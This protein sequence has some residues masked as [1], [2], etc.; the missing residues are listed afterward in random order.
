LST[1]S[2]ASRGLPFG[3]S[4]TVMFFQT[5]RRGNAPL[6]TMQAELREPIT[7]RLSISQ[8]FAQTGKSISGGIGA[9]YTSGFTTVAFDY[10]NYYV[11]LREPNPFMRALNLTIRLQLGNSSVNI[12][13]TVDPFGRVTYAASGSTYLYMGELAPGVQ[14]LTI[15]FERYVIRGFVQDERGAPI[16]GAAL[17]VGGEIV[18]TNSRGEFFVRTKNRRQLPLR[19]AFDDFLAV[20]NFEI[21]SAPGSVTPGEEDRAEPIRVVL[22]AVNATAEPEPA[23][24][25]LGIQPQGA[26][27]ARSAPPRSAVPLPSAATSAQSTAAFAQCQGVHGMLRDLFLAAMK[28]AA[29]R[30]CC[31]SNDGWH[32]IERPL[33]IIKY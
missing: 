24:R 7:R 8:V 17:D 3:T 32:I 14:P 31:R 33:P 26:P 21:M 29:P 15:R 19:V 4:G 12:G 10:Q 6:R 18:T 13:T 25:L 27:R 28:T 23:K 16:E 20:G 1:F 11:P 22:R 30:G 9:Q 5:F 2:S